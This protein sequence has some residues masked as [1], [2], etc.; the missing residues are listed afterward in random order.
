MGAIASPF[1]KVLKW[2]VIA[3]AS[4]QYDR[5]ARNILVKVFASLLPSAVEN[6]FTTCF[7]LVGL[8]LLYLMPW[9]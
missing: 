9:I 3:R 2:E 4:R 6:N 8:Q 7:L 1:L 5:P